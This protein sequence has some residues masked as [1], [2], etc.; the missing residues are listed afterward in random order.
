MSFYKSLS[1]LTLKMEQKNIIFVSGNVNEIIDT[2]M[3][4]YK[5]LFNLLDVDSSKNIINLIEHICRQCEFLDFNTIK[6]FTP[7]N[8]IVNFFDKNCSK[9]DDENSDDE[10]LEISTSK[11]LDSFIDE[12]NNE[13]KIIDDLNNLGKRLYIIDCGDILLEKQSGSSQSKIANLVELFT[14]LENQNATIL[15]KTKLKLVI[16]ARNQDFINQ[17][18]YRNNIEHS[19]ITLLL[20]NK[21][22]R[23]EFYKEYKERFNCLIDT[24]K[25]IDHQDYR[26]VIT[27]TDG[28]SLREIFQYAKISKKSNLFL[29]NSKVSFKDLY[30]LINFNKQ[31]SEW[32]KIDLQKMKNINEILSKRVKGQDEAIQIVKSTLIRS[33]TGMN[34]I[35]HS[36]SNN[37]KPKGALFFVGPTGT[38]K[39][40]LAKSISEFVFG[41]ETRIIRFDMSEFNQEHSDQRLIGAPPGYVGHSSG[42]ELTNAVKQ[43]PFSILLFDEIEKAHPRIL[44]K[45]LQILED[46]RLT[47]SQGEV[48]DF[49][50]TFIIFTSN[51]GAKDVDKINIDSNKEIHKHFISSVS[52]FFKNEIGRPELLNRIGYKNIVPFNFVTNEGIISNIINSKLLSFGEQLKKDKNIDLTYKNNAKEIIVKEVIKK[53]DKKMGGR[54]II[55][56]LETV[57]IDKLSSSMFQK[58]NV[59]MD[60]I[61]NKKITSIQC[62]INNGEIEFNFIEN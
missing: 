7:K 23:E 51:I 18:I 11:N 21:D 41:E 5:E 34:G 43:K 45:F 14:N 42:G 57:F 13:I 29:S 9:E 33:F 30:K 40:E 52:N 20:P 12:I 8:G 53:Y 47:S 3:N 38:G 50:E 55:T 17:L 32:E 37:R 22:E 28:M 48:I 15:H 61:K 19:S 10:F 31:E 27:Y 26:D 4:S 36:S 44:D 1:Q 58:Y 56:E 60:N 54:G 24:C 39:T 35:L 62:L 49:S 25:D 16:I 46:G 59:I 2:N 6:F